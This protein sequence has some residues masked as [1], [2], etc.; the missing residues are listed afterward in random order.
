MA[1]RASD[2]PNLAIEEFDARRAAGFDVQW[3]DQATL[4]GRWG[5]DGTGGDRIGARCIRRPVR[6][7]LPRP[8]APSAGGAGGCSNEPRSVGFEFRPSRA[9][10]TR[11]G[12]RSTLGRWCCRRDTKCR[13]CSRTP[14]QPAQLVRV[15]D[16]TDRRSLPRQF[17]DGLLFWDFDDPYLYGRT[18]DDT[19]LLIGGKDENYR[20]PL[21]RRRALP[22]KSAPS[23]ARFRS[24]CPIWSRSRS[25]SRGAARSPR[26]PTGSPTS[27][28]TRGSRGA[29][30]RSGSAA[31]ASPTAHW[32]PSTSPTRSTGPARRNRLGCS[33]SNGHPYRPAEHHSIV[34]MQPDRE[35]TS[36]GHS[37]PPGRRW[38]RRWESNPR[39][40]ACKAEIEPISTSID[41]SGF[42]P[43]CAI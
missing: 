38:W 41:L 13:S 37:S 40:P 35:S 3:L 16:R 31:T 19:R 23:P 9:P 10:V 5:L 20:D 39:P 33:T 34:E 36:A 22:S 26:L 30:S 8:R 32:P 29:T 42:V 27:D 14:V 6:A 12:A 17:P 15:G 18:T 24:D 1:I 4:R 2:I 7:Q 25:P 43:D 28:R 11:A 21:R